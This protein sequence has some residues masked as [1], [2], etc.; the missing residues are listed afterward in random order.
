[1]SF[2]LDRLSLLLMGIS[3]LLSTVLTFTQIEGSVLIFLAIFIFFIPDYQV[4]LIR[5]L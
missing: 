3:T 5:Q 4:S 2:H 1:M